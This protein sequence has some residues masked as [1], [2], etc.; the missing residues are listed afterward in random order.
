MRVNTHTKLQPKLTAVIVFSTDSQKHPCMHELTVCTVVQI[1][2]SA[3][4][5]NSLM[6]RHRKQIVSLLFTTL[7]AAD[8]PFP[9]RD[10]EK[11]VTNTRAERK[12]KTE[13]LKFCVRR[14]ES[15]RQNTEA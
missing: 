14:K 12:L 6:S 13:V 9:V 7:K 5:K 11:L 8:D 1:Q 3:E 2:F 10:E 4:C 15:A